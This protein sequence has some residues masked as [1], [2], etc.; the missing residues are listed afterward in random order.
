MTF[1][2]AHIRELDKQTE[3]REAELLA[4]ATRFC[5]PLR[6]RPELGALFQELETDAAADSVAGLRRRRRRVSNAPDTTVKTVSLVDEDGVLYWRD[7]VPAAMPGRRRRGR[8]HRA[9]LRGRRA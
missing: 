8:R 3:K 4:I 2:E 7:G 1:S 6:A 9:R 5:A